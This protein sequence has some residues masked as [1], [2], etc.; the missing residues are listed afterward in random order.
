MFFSFSKITTKEILFG[1]T[2]FILI[3]SFFAFLSGLNTAF[4]KYIS[5]TGFYFIESAVGNTHI[6]QL[7]RANN[8]SLS[9]YSL[10]Y[11]LNL[12][13]SPSV[14]GI[15][16]LSPM[17]ALMEMPFSKNLKSS[18]GVNYIGNNLFSEYAIVA[19][20]AYS[21]SDKVHLGASL[22]HSRMTIKDFNDES[23]LMVNLGSIIEI[24]EFLSTGFSLT[25][26]NRAYFEGGKD[27]PNQK[28][29][30]GASYSA[31]EYLFFDLDIIV[32][33]ERS[34]GTAIA[35]RYDFLDFAS[36]RLAYLTNPAGFEAGVRINPSDFLS[37][38]SEISY[39]N[40]LG[41]SSDFG[42]VLYLR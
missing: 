15:K 35:A 22:C 6:N 9:V 23:L 11:S 30:F 13:Y 8:P 41:F 34:S 16:E 14:F 24:N 37:I 31:S 40:F 25:N 28:A 33:F 5:G 39:H 12:S 10:D 29:V 36:I 7:K 26:I 18:M 27:T 2:L 20:A 32:M 1:N 4:A 42:I 19:G 21:L 17:S 38:V 3:V